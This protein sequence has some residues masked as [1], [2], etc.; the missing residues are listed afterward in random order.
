[1]RRDSQ[2]VIPGLYIGPLQSSKDLTKLQ[3]SGITHVLCIYDEREA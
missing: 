3:S 2:E 1:M